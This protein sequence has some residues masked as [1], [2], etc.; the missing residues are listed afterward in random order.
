MSLTEQPEFRDGFMHGYMAGDQTTGGNLK[1]IIDMPGPVGDPGPKGPDSTVVGP[2][3]DPGLTGLDGPIGFEGDKGAT[4]APGVDNF[5]TGPTGPDGAKG[6]DGASPPGDQ[7]DPGLD[8]IDGSL[9]K[10]IT[11]IQFY[12]DGHV[13]TYADLSVASVPDSN[14]L[15][16][17][18]TLLGTT[19]INYTDGNMP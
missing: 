9:Q 13:I 11:D 19:T 15:D 2:E 1:S 16:E 4:G 10:R 17:R 6:P 5:V 8:G 12:A 18:I 3:G 7:G 14:D